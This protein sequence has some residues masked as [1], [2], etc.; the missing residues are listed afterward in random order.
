MMGL[1]AGALAFSDPK[2]RKLSLEDMPN[3]RT[4]IGE[5]TQEELDFLDK[6][7]KINQGCKIFEFKKLDEDGVE[8]TIEIVALNKKNAI[9]KYN[10]LIR[11]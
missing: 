4:M 6:A 8:R 2:N 11:S 1:L 9:R 10:K 3:H 7:R 5:K